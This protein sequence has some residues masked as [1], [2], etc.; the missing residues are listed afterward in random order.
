MTIL[1]ML[2]LLVAALML[3]AGVFLY[4]RKPA[5]GEDDGDD[6]HY[7]SQGAVLLFVVAV[8]MVIHGVGA[9][10]YHPSASEIE[11]AKGLAGM[12]RQ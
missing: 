5:K 4:R 11:M 1:S 10:E 8:I 7:G 12:G 6:G 3:A 2:E 9:L